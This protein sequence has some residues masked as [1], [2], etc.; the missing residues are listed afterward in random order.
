MQAMGHDIKPMKVTSIGE[1]QRNRFRVYKDADAFS[2]TVKQLSDGFEEQIS[3]VSWNQKEIR[4]M[5]SM[6]AKIC[7]APRI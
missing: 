1:V 4:D 7:S 3:F 6:V 2:F 5:R